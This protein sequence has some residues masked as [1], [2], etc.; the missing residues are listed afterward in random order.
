MLQTDR[1][2]W[3]SSAKK[4]QISAILQLGQSNRIS[5]LREVYIVRD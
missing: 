2:T 5:A 3:D 4:E 1:K